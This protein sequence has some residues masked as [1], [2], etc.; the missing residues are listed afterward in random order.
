MTRNDVIRKLQEH[1]L[2]L[3]MGKNAFPS[4]NEFSETLEAVN[5]A[6]ELLR[7]MPNCDECVCQ[8]CGLMANGRNRRETDEP[9]RR[10]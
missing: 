9:Q 5:G 4:T 3:E 8:S 6:I 10:D 1:T 7:D 2:T